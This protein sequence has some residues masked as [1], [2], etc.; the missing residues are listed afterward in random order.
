MQISQISDPV[1]REMVEAAVAE[2]AY[3]RATDG[4]TNGFDAQ[5]FAAFMPEHTDEQISE[6]W[7]AYQAC[8]Q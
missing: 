3:V 1:I 6:A 2:D 7:A 8:K 5:G 4:E